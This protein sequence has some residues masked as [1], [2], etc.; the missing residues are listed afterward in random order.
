MFH[1]FSQTVENQK[2]GKWTIEDLE[3][4]FFL[5]FCAIFFISAKNLRNLSY[6]TALLC[7]C[8]LWWCS[9]VLLWACWQHPSGFL[10]ILVLV[11]LLHTSL[12]KPVNVLEVFQHVRLIFQLLVE[13][14][15]YFQLPVVLW[16]YQTSDDVKSS[17]LEAVDY[18]RV[19]EKQESFWFCKKK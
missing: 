11:S 2:K 9:S 13:T 16:L 4:L 10:H 15:S 8:S 17:I 19:W 12:D 18:E 6:F 7:L 14:A 3:N 1:L 5:F